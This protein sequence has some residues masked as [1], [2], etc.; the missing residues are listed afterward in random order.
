MTTEQSIPRLEKGEAKD[1]LRK[2]KGLKKHLSPAQQEYLGYA[3]KSVG[4]D[5]VQGYD[6]LVTNY[7]IFDQYGDL[8]G[9]E[10][11]DYDDYGNYQGEVVI[12]Y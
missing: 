9:E 5:E 6:W 4:G 7:Y 12:G 1:L 2:L 10:D 3:L 11:S 8:I